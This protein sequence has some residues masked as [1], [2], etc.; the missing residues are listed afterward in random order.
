MSKSTCE[1]GVEGGAPRDAESLPGYLKAV[2]DMG[3]EF[4]VC[5]F[6]P[7]RYAPGPEATDGKPPS[8][9]SAISPRPAATRI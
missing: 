5:Q 1:F 7:E 2:H 8:R 9:A 6:G 3:A 4:I